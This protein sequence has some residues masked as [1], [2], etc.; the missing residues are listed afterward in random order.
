[1]KDLNFDDVLALEPSQ[2]LKRAKTKGWALSAIGT[3]IYGVL[4]TFGLKP[5]NYKNICPYF[6]I[7]KHW[8]GFELGWF[9]ICD[10]SCGDAVQAHEVGHIIQNAKVGGLKTLCLSMCSAVRY[11]IRKIKG[12]KTP[13]DSWWFESQATKLGKEYLERRQ[14]HE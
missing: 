8:G 7:G 12:S 9:F 13:Y 5:Q 6:T 3:L 1:M 10:K 2:L 4:R 14:Q 11:W